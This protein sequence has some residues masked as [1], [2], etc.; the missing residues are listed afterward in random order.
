MHH[1]MPTYEELKAIPPNNWYPECHNDLYKE[2]CDHCMN[3][4]EVACN[5][6]N[7]DRLGRCMCCRTECI[8]RPSSDHVSN[9]S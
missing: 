9:L 8:C 1:F 6:I 5:R 4:W 3:C 7:C 2:K